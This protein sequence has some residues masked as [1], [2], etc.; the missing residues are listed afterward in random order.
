VDR[1]V[2][3]LRRLGFQAVELPAEA[4]GSA[5]A[6]IRHLVGCLVAAGMLPADQAEDACHRVLHREQLGPTAIGEGVAI[7]HATTPAVSRIVGVGARSTGVPWRAPD[8]LPVQRITLV[9]SPPDHPGPYLRILEALSQG[10][11]QGNS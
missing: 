1:F 9:I 10:L 7:P 5:E 3:L 4:S 6:A 8:G 2:E 11:R